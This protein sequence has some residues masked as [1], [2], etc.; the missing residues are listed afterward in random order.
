MRFWHLAAL[1]LARRPLRSVLTVLGIAVAVACFVVMVGLSRGVER[2]WLRNLQT[3]NTHVLGVKKGAID[4]LSAFLDA[5]VGNRIEQMDGVSAVAAELVDMMSLETDETTIAQGWPLGCYLWETLQLTEGRLPAADE[6][7]AVVLGQSLAEVIH[8]RPGDTLRAWGGTLRVVGVFRTGSVIGNNSVTLPLRT[9]QTMMTRQGKVTAFNLRLA[10]P[11][12]PAAVAAVRARL[13]A[14]FPELSFT[15][16]SAV[17][18]HDLVLR[19]FRAMAWSVS[20]TA[21]LIALVVVV[22]TL[23]MSV[24]ERTREIGILSA[25][26]WPAKR[27]VALIVAEGGGLGL[28]GGCVGLTLG[29]TVLRGVTSLP[30]VRGFIEVEL[31]T[32]LFAEV[33]V[34]VVLLGVLGSLYPAWRGANL[35]AVEAL[36]HE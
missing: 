8:K 16:T 17:A 10:R 9:M 12:D 11:N 1:N 35:N 36:Q 18:D 15:E 33:M 29:A 23:L 20:L 21:L 14:A 26:G 30:R 13:Q 6:T 24:L 27:I 31:T 28:L 25:I 22:N 2:A 34:G 32:G 3:R 5:N 19:F 7:N 4:I